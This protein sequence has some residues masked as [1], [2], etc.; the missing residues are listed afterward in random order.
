MGDG[1]DDVRAG[2]ASVRRFLRRVW[3]GMHIALG[4]VICYV[5]IAGGD[6]TAWP[7]FGLGSF[8]VVSGGL[9]YWMSR[10]PSRRA[11]P[12]PPPRTEPPRARARPKK[13]KWSFD[14]PAPAPT[15]AAPQ[16]PDPDDGPRI[17]K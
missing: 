17:L 7:I 16:P 4:L 2:L 11:D 10:S 5:A 15:A 6:G 1:Y 8:F 3:G 12:A 9:I 13:T 14:P